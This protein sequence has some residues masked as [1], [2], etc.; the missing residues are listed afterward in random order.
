MCLDGVS[1]GR[2][3]DV[4]CGSGRFLTLMRDAGW[5]VQGVEPDPVSAQIARDRHGIPVT[6]GTLPQA[7]FPDRSFDAITMNHVIE[8]V[9]DPLALL[10]ECRRVL[11]PGGNVVVVT[12]N[13]RSFGHRKFKDCW[14]GLEPPRHLCL[15]SMQSLGAAAA[16]AGLEA[17][18]IRTSARSARFIGTASH[19]LRRT[20]HFS[21][22]DVAWGSRLRGLA[23]RARCHA[24]L[25]GDPHSGEEIVLLASPRP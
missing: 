25:L 19:A 3:L 12:P 6:A 21:D 24:A 16:K 17:K 14:R 13:V 10:A 22:A 4:G 20:G 2:L 23:F 11:R 18:E 1:H 15:F 5:E 9:A 8:H 7:A